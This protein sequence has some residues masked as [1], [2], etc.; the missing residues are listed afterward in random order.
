MN[1]IQYF[2]QQLLGD[3]AEAKKF[4][5]P[6]FHKGTRTKH[7]QHKRKGYTHNHGKGESKVRRK[8]AARSRRINRRYQ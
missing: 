6:W 2:I 3:E 8:M 1:V 5:Q 7:P 4:H